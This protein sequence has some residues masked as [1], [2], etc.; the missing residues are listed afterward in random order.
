MCGFFYTLV[1]AEKCYGNGSGA[2]VGT[3]CASNDRIGEIA[4][5]LLPQV[6]T[7][8]HILFQHMIIKA[9]IP[10]Q[11]GLFKIHTT[12]SFNFLDQKI[13]PLSGT[14]GLAQDLDH[15]MLHTHHRLL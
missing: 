4:D 6:G 7:V 1:L 3:N 5:L 8:L 9:G 2:Y 13:I 14:A 11:Y 15:T 12:G 10:Q